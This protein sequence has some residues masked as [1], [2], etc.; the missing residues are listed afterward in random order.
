M[1]RNIAK[2]DRVRRRTKKL[3]EKVVTNIK[4]RE[5]VPGQS[6]ILKKGDENELESKLR[7]EKVVASNSSGWPWRRKKKEE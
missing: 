3:Q 5:T 1:L 4:P 7:L 6:Q 2:K